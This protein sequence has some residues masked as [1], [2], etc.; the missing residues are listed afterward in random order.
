[1]TSPACKKHDGS[2]LDRGMA[3]R[4]ITVKKKASHHCDVSI[5]GRRPPSPASAATAKGNLADGWFASSEIHKSGRRGTDGTSGPENRNGPRRIVPRHQVCP[6]SADERSFAWSDPGEP[7]VS[8]TRSPET[9]A[10][11]ALL[12]RNYDEGHGAILIFDRQSLR[13]RYSIEP[14]HDVIC[15]DEMG[16][17]DE[18]EERIWRRHVIDVGKHLIGI[19]FGPTTQCSDAHKKHNREYTTRMEARLRKLP[20]HTVNSNGLCIPST[21]AGL[22]F[23]TERAKV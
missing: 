2:N 23:N 11:W 15:D 21:A 3:M 4:R 19:V 1:M 22:Q 6:I 16:R 14:Y 8:F 5:A 9:A 20:H 7:T 13:C 18:A 17:N 10:Y 12:Q